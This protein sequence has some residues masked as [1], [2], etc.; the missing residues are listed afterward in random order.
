MASSYDAEIVALSMALEWLMRNQDKV[1]TTLWIFIDNKGVIQ[2]SLN[3]DAHSNQMESVRI[4]LRLLHLFSKT[5]LNKVYLTYCPS[6]TGI[7]GNE[8]ADNMASRT[9]PDA[10]GLAV[11]KQHF[12]EEKRHI[13]N[14]EWRRRVSTSKYRGMQWL[15]VWYNKKRYIPKIGSTAKRK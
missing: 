1:R 9:L 15:A 2:G 4:N 6:H 12:M 10:R 13:M 14:E 3:M 8:R 11:L 5:Q 7:E